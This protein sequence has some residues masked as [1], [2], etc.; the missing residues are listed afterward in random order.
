[1]NEALAIP[2]AEL[3]R[4]GVYHP[5]VTSGQMAGYRALAKTGG[6]LTWGDVARIETN[7]HAFH[8]EEDDMPSPEVERFAKILVEQVRDA[9]I[10]G[11]DI[12]LRPKARSVTAERWRAAGV[13]KGTQSEV[14]IP[15]SV[16]A[17]IYFLLKAIDDGVLHL[18]L[19][20]PSGREIDLNA[21]GLG[22]LAGWY[23]GP[24]GWRDQYS[25]KRLVDSEDD[26]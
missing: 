5:D 23:V 8:G 19:V 4:L 21:D 24:D 9:A 26:G 3:K 14:L 2:N 1:M 16:D 25:T 20:D 7:A 13:S 10:S 12:N 11:L 15:D 17:A 18:K 6:N 22:E